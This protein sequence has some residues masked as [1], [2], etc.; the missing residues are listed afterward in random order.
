MSNHKIAFQFAGV[1]PSDKK[2]SQLEKHWHR[3]FR[4]IE[5]EFEARS[6]N[7]LAPLYAKRIHGQTFQLTLAMR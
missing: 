7:R 1:K 5:L 6:F 2:L 3:F 4:T